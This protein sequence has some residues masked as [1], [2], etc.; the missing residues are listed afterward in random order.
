MSCRLLLTRVRR[1]RLL[2][3]PQVPSAGTASVMGSDLLNFGIFPSENAHGGCAPFFDLP[4]LAV[5]L[6]ERVSVR[7]FFEFFVS[8]I[9]NLHTRCATRAP[10]AG[11]CLSA[12][13][14]ACRVR[15]ATSGVMSSDGHR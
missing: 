6:G 3:R 14:A 1:E 5:S 13:Q 2:R 12:G 4:M 8:A 9:R 15:R 11:S 10:L 7:R